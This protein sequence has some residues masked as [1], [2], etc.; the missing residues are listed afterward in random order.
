VVSAPSPLRIVFFGTPEFAVPTLT[1]LLESRHTVCGV[2]TQPDRARGR[3]QHVTPSPVKAL[4]IAHQLPVVQPTRL[5]DP[6]LLATIADWRPDLGVVVAYGRIIP[7][8]LLSLPPMGLINVHASLLPKYRGAAPVHRA[9]IDGQAETGVTIMRVVTLLDAGQM[10]ATRV[11]PIGPDETSDVVERD[12]SRIGADLLLEVVD[13]MAAGPVAGEPQDDTLSTYAPRLT[14]EEGLLDW[15]LPAADLHN[16]IRG[17]HPW[18]LACTYLDGQ[19]LTIRRAHVE[20]GRTDQEPGTVV[21]AGKDTLQVATGDGGLIGIDE[22]QAD[23]RRPL[24]TREFL[25][26]RPIAAGARLTR[27]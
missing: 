2:V 26:G 11:R 16:R 9:V 3:G 27:Q 19:R 14:K 22:I 25:A 18:P 6:D 13:A 5:A 24:A 7:D 23:G 8:A 10:I 1:R 20:A 4:A 15:S 21:H 17:L 12:L